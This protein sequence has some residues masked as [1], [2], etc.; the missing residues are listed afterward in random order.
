MA[1]VSVGARGRPVW[2]G[3]LAMLYIILGVVTLIPQGYYILFYAHLVT[4]SPHA[5]LLGQV[6]YWYG[7]QIDTGALSTDSGT[8]TG[9]VEDAFLLGPL[10]IAC[11][12]GL[13]QRRAW[14]FPVGMI[15]GGGAL[16]AI[17]Y[18]ILTYSFDHLSSVT[19]LLVFW[20]TTLPY[21]ALP[22]WLLS[23]LLTRRALFTEADTST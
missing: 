1:S 15:T 20:V 7:T 2:L 21:L 19:G 18:F 9:A 23:T 14:V 8:V 3:I 17:L 10:Y 13:W 5:N 16:Y 4:A 22:I 12:I 6:W 11:G